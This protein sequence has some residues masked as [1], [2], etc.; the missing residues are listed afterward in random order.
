MPARM[1][2]L[3]AEYCLFSRC[4][5]GV[6][7]GTLQRDAE[8]VR[9]FLSLLRN[10]GK[11]VGRVTIAEIDA[12]VQQLAERFSKRTV[13]RACTALR[14]FLRF[15]CSTGC[16]RRDL[17]ACVMAPRV[18]MAERP[19]RALPWADVKRIL[20]S[21]PQGQSPG[22]PGQSHLKRSGRV[23]GWDRLGG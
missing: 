9:A 20:Y 21:I 10:R 13:A 17:A 3:L 18:R 12:F 16:L 8:E 4:H 2:P 7:E 23:V 11:S 1:P 5:R 6:A 22:K 15:L 14:S 19:P